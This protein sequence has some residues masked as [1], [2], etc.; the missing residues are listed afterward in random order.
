MDKTVLEIQRARWG[1]SSS[2]TFSSS[3]SNSG[4]DD[5][6]LRLK[7]R[8]SKKVT[9]DDEPPQLINPGR[10]GKKGSMGRKLVA[11]VGNLCHAPRGLE[12]GQDNLTSSKPLRPKPFHHDYHH[13]LSSTQFFGADAASIPPRSPM[14][15]N[16]IAET[17][18]TATEP[19]NIDHINRDLPID[20]SFRKRRMDALRRNTKSDIPKLG[21]IE[22]K[23]PGSIVQKPHLSPGKSVGDRFKEY[24]E[25][26][27]GN[28]CAPPTH[29]SFPPSGAPA[30]TAQIDEQLSKSLD[31]NICTCGKR[32]IKNSEN[33][34]PQ[35]L[36]SDTSGMAPAGPDITRNVSCVQLT[37]K[38]TSGKSISTNTEIKLSDCPK[39]HIGSD[40]DNCSI[41]TSATRTCA[42]ESPI[43]SMDSAFGTSLQI[44][45]NKK[46]IIS[47]H[48]SQFDLNGL[49]RTRKQSALPQDD[50]QPDNI[51]PYEICR[52][53]DPV[54]D[55]SVI[56]R[57]F[58]P[59]YPNK[60][61]PTVEYRK[62]I[63]GVGNWYQWPP[64]QVSKEYLPEGLKEFDWSST[65]SGKRGEK[66]PQ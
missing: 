10:P 55:G 26:T 27:S 32:H 2:I 53:D 4:D 46:T 15:T 40:F 8:T 41:C 11:Q 48:P 39:P 5:N 19:A 17:G 47:P 42:V 57:G 22:A 50:V 6:S 34:A 49:P 9:W 58:S 3:Q 45:G 12:T 31:K 54:F 65:G 63:G 64:V 66:P 24:Q 56:Q 51:Q 62:R 37:D 16:N 36:D 14:S 23:Q 20:L 60:E 28:H 25:R 35:K 33:A 44:S 59:Q 29:H 43:G 18:F 21:V 38:V 1:I 61:A 30:D 13:P 7:P 52:S